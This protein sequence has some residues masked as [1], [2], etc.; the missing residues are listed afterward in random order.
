M[1]KKTLAR[2]LEIKSIDDSG[3]FEGYGSVFGNEDSYGDVVKHGAF[4]KTLADF[5]TKG[6][7]PAML[8]QH[9]SQQPIGVYTEMRED[10]HGLVVKGRLLINDD[11]LAKRAH[12]HMKAGSVSGLS[13][14]YSVPKGGGTWNEKDGVYELSQINLFE[15]SI[16]TFPAN[17]QA[18]VS[19]V[20]SAFETVR[21]LEVFL[22]GAGM[23]KSEACALIAKGGAGVVGRGE[24]DYTELAELNAQLTALSATLRN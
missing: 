22:R 3:T 7:F 2:P 13:I 18:Q 10:E 23:S 24:H 9:D 17:E 14:G 1:Q 8:W 15:V 16:V 4:T 12:A 19:G 6:K 21:S 20:K 5:K 11:P